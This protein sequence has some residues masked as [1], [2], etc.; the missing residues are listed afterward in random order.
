MTLKLKFQK[1]CPL[2]LVF[3]T[4]QVCF[5]QIE[6]TEHN[7]ADDFD[8]ATSVYAIDID[9]DGDM[10]VLGAAVVGYITWWEN[11]GDQEFAEHR[12]DSNFE[13][14]RCVRAGDFDGDGD[15]DVLGAGRN[16]LTW[17]ENDGGWEFT[18]HNI[19][20]NFFGAASVCA[21]DI[22]SDGDMDVLGAASSAGDITWWENDGEQEFTRHNIAREFHG[23]WS[24]HAANIDGDGDMDVLGAARGFGIT[25]WENDGEQEFNGHT[26]TDNFNDA[27]SVYATDIDND[28]DMDIIG[29]AAS[30]NNIT[31]WENDGEQEF[32]EH[33]IANEFNGAVSV[34]AADINFDGDL[35]VLGA[36]RNAGEITW[37]ENDG[38]QD[39]NGHTIAD[40]FNGAH[41]VYATDIDSDGDMDV[42]GAA[43]SANNIT[44]WEND[45]DPTGLLC[46][47]VIDAENDNPLEVVT[48]TTS[49]N[50]C[51]QS[52]SAG[53][54]RLERFRSN[55]FDIMF[56]KEG[57]NDSIFIDQQIEIDDTLEFNIGLL[58]PECELSEDMFFETWRGA[59]LS[60]DISMSNPGNGPLEYTARA[61][62]E[63]E[64]GM[65]PFQRRRVYNVGETLGESRVQCVV[66]VNDRYYVAAGGEGYPS[67]YFLNRE[68]EVQ[69]RFA[70]PI[71]DIRGMRD[72]TWDGEL[73]WGT[74]N[75]S[76]Y[77]FNT[78]GDVVFRWQSPI[79]PT[80]VITWDSTNELIW[81]GSTLRGLIGFDRQGNHIDGCQIECNE[82]R[83]YG[84]AYFPE[85]EAP[86]YIFTR[87][88]E[89][90]QE[91]YKVNPDDGNIQYV[92]EITPEEGG[93]P[94]GCFI[95]QE[96]DP[97]GGWIFMNIADNAADDRIDVWQLKANTDWIGFERTEGVVDAN[98]SVEFHIELNIAG[99]DSMIYPGIL[100]F[101][102]NAIP[103]SDTIRITLELPVI[104]ERESTV[105]K[106]FTISSIHPNPFNSTTTI[107]Y[108]LPVASNV[109]LKLF[110]L[111]GRLIQTLVE[112]EEQAGVKTTIVNAAELPSGLY[113]ARLSASGKVFTRKVMLVR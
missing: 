12:I 94:Q 3:V 80:T 45:L 7:I 98:Q 103:F 14:A 81:L 35:D 2:L 61:S 66:Y 63:G 70:Q 34:Y 38:E 111:T 89:D 100:V 102:H 67:I 65:L 90:N 18:E 33:T 62:L 71:E 50:Y 75:D 99:L 84:L 107:T 87:S 93:T 40:N 21:I 41:S 39:F 77:G 29:A 17:W 92:T 97:F 52:D 26:I 88:A 59:V 69:G 16:H 108:G 101:D 83:I 46:G 10:D 76:V 56:S 32:S 47:F 28:G 86:L 20:D 109:S 13:P 8:G 37:W 57:Y 1:L 30:D 51:A 85:D 112:G 106:E 43:V 22:D 95:T 44:W 4:A 24:V 9:R 91:I 82:L 72:L 64:S 73:L 5:A 6:F 48:V 105:A 58:H 27:F 54:W 15:I 96:Y 74:I 78:E 11:D 110:D 53:F 25:W 113:F 19:A 36:A 49:D 31:W 68:G 104:E 79:N 60:G 23:A 42:L 55:A